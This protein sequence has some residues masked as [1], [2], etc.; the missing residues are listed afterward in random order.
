MEIKNITVIIRDLDN[1]IKSTLPNDITYLAI[2]KKYDNCYVIW[3]DEMN[4]ANSIKIL[5]HELVHIQQYNNKKL[6][7]NNNK[8]YWEQK[9]YFNIEYVNYNNRPWENEAFKKQTDLSTRIKF[10]LI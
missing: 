10:R 3:I 2:V 6:M 4:K 9:E 5:S 8:I 1:N 7:I